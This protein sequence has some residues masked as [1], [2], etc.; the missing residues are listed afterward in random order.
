M[1]GGKKYTLQ[2]GRRQSEIPRKKKGGE[3]DIKPLEHVGDIERARNTEG[4]S[5]NQNKNKKK[6][7]D[8]RLN[9]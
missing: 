4:Y 7:C 5:F 8:A 6:N 3:N 9:Q 1:T 2:A